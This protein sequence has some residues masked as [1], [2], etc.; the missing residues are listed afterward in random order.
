MMQQD[1]PWRVSPHEEETGR[2]VGAVKTRI[3]GFAPHG[4]LVAAM[5]L[6]FGSGVVVT[7]RET[8]KRDA[9]HESYG[10]SS[11]RLDR[12]PGTT[13][14]YFAPNLGQWRDESIRFAH[15]DGGLRV[16]FRDSTV[17]LSMRGPSNP[18]P[19]VT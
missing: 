5:W 19:L 6:S 18:G 12:I 14:M 8:M 10:S 11:A 16:A 4:L 9:A 17:T 13:A 7:G 2:M 1:R 3:Q 15:H